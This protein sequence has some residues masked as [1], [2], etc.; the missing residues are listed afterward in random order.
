MKK[1][2][3]ACLLALSAGAVSALASCGDNADNVVDSIDIVENSIKA[4]YTMDSTPSYDDL[5]INLLNASKQTI[6]TLKYTEN[7]ETISHTDIDTSI[8]GS[9]KVFTVTY[10]EGENLFQDTM[11]YNVTDKYELD[12]W[13][14][15]KNYVYTTT[16]VSNPTL[17][18]SE[19]SLENG[20][21]KA[22]SGSYIVG[23]M[24]AVNLLPE[25]LAFDL[26]SEKS[27]QTVKL[28]KIPAGATMKL[29][30][31]GTEVEPSEYIS[32]VAAFLSDGTLKFKD[33]VSGDFKIALSH[34]D[35][36]D[37][38][39]YELTVVTGYNVSKATDLFAFYT[40]RDSWPYSTALSNA[41]YE[42][43]QSLGLPDAE[44]IILQNDIT[45]NKNDL[46]DCYYWKEGEAEE[47]AVVGSLKDWLRMF[48]HH[49][50][51]DNTVAHVYGNL[52]TL[53]INDKKD[54]PNAVPY[55]LT[56]SQSGKAQE[57]GEAISSH[58][59]LFYASF[60][61]SDYTDYEGVRHLCTKPENCSIVFQDLQATGN[62]GVSAESSIT[63]GGPMFLKTE[64]DANFDNVILSKYYM[65]TMADASTGGSKTYNEVDLQTAMTISNSRI[66]DCANA[67]AYIYGSGSLKIVNSELTS[68]GGPLLFLNPGT[69]VLPSDPTAIASYQPKIATTVDI[70]DASF[71]SNY[72]QGK[73]GWF[74]CYAGA[75]TMAG[76]LTS[77][78]P[79]FQQL[80]MSF[81]KTE[82]DLSS[83]TPISKFSFIMV[84]LPIAGGESLSLPSLDKGGVNVIV[85][86]GG[87]VVYSTLDGYL[88]VMTKAMA[89]STAATSGDAT[90]IATA[91][92]DYIGKL[93]GTFFGN[94]LAYC[95]Y[96]Q[97]MVFATTSM[98]TGSH[99]F[100][101]INTD[102]SLCSSEYVIKSALK[103]TSSTDVSTPGDGIK[104]AGMLA[105]TINGEK[106]QVYSDAMAM[107]PTAYT[108]VANYGVLLGDYHAIN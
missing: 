19:D 38:V 5:A 56:E 35:I 105:V 24:N 29:E 71:L 45:I 34:S 54:D 85:R 12:S 67:G 70:D 91:T 50:S 98:T 88:D 8:V 28:D 76:A 94:N 4:S 77:V 22:N 44:N 101:A 63:N 104:D 3:Y 78:N 49:F 42:Y 60:P 79:L 96:A 59:A 6:K 82:K 106:S 21:I 52:H 27:V 17:S 9:N 51:V 10:T 41:V 73:G 89:Y 2:R 97:Q 26:S 92:L 68:A 33:N 53:S 57:E 87:K 20:F 1:V 36:D 69:E 93:S 102:L 14:A 23:N 55:I 46:P 39:V 74:D 65:A 15:N 32:D 107:N 86:K 30:K 58:S 83:D 95:N 81:L 64:V 18:S 90:A 80:G 43:K 7:K 62:R 25:M 31:D 16:N 75:S 13:S 47:K 48:D 99:E 40:C 37:S 103:L 84:N 108:G 61:R 66:R 72:T 11:T 100:A